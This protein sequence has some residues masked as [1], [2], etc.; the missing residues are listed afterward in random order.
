MPHA[1]QADERVLPAAV[2]VAVVT[3]AQRRG[4]AAQPGAVAQPLAPVTEV[5]YV[6]AE[7]AHVLAEVAGYAA[8]E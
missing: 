5:A 2:V 4:S 8:V 7:V 1:E 6:P 3:E